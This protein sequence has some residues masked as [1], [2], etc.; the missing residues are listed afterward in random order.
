MFRMNSK[1]YSTNFKR[2]IVVYASD[3]PSHPDFCWCILQNTQHQKAVQQI[4]W[5]ATVHEH[6]KIAL[7]TVA[8]T[9]S[10]HPIY[11]GPLHF[12]RLIKRRCLKTNHSNQW[13][14]DV[15]QVTTLV[16]FRVDGRPTTA[17][18]DRLQQLNNT[19]KVSSARLSWQWL[20][21]LVPSLIMTIDPLRSPQCLADDCQLSSTAG[22]RRLRSSNV[23][24]VRCHELA[25]IW[26]IAHSLLLEHVWGT[27]YFSI[28][29]TL[30]ILSWS[31]D[32]Y[33]FCWGQR[34]LVTVCFLCVL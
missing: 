23:P 10:A 16:Y 1:V 15:H 28:Y 2:K 25:Q 12:N 13:M 3:A 14:T 6:I 11:K 33:L 19:W 27:T 18:A 29:V 24:R 9:F 32:G 26:A 17:A 4:W 20:G 8:L 21:H 34:H 5:C 30:N 22:R 31:S 7:L